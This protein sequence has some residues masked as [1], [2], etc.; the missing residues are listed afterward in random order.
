[1]AIGSRIERRL[2]QAVSDAQGAGA[3]PLL[4]A[5]LRY[6][7]FPGGHRIR[8]RLCLSVAEACGAAD[9]AAADAAAAAIELLHCASLVHDDLPCF[10][11]ADLRRGKASVHCEFGVPIAVLT[12][13]AL[14]VLAFETLTKGSAESP[15]CLA[16]LATIIAGAVGSPRGIVAGQ[17]WE[18]EAA[19]SLSDYQRAKTGALFLAATMAGAAAA[20]V[21]SK[22]WGV[23]GL[24]LG[25]AYQ[26]ADDLRDVLCDAEELGKPIDQDAARFRPNAAA[27]LGVEGAKARLKTLIR[28]AMDSIPACPGAEELRAIIKRADAA[29]PARAAGARGRLRRRRCPPRR[30]SVGTAWRW[31]DVWIGLRN[32]LIADPGFQRWAA[33]FPLTKLIARRRARALFDLCAGFVYSQILL[34]CVRLGVFDLL[35]EGPQTVEALASAMDLSPEAA[36]RLL[37]A[38][39]S[40]RLLRALPGNRFALADLGASLRGNPSIAAFIEHHSLLYD[41]LRDPVALLRGQ[42]GTKLSRFWPYS[43]ARPKAGDPKAA[44][45][46]DIGETPSPLHGAYSELMSASQALVGED[47]LDAYP[48]DRHRALLDVGGGEGAFLAIAAKRSPRLRLALFRPAARRRAGAQGPGNPGTRRPARRSSPAAFSTTRCRKAAMWRR[49]CGSSTITTTNRAMVI[50]RRCFQAL[51]AGGVLLLAEPM[52]GTPGAEPWAT[53]ISA[54]TCWRWAGAVR[55]RPPA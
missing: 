7:V 43:E 41:D 31:G 54:S 21:D 46:A 6:A 17:A 14:I 45:A 24:T 44:E 23:L 12:G 39:T 33:A 11:D 25:E 42:A 27:L 53:L 52:A 2:D 18:C 47:I 5:A 55:G 22:P 38:A 3:P 16:S 1:M 9:P 51:P 28:E 26:V 15:A 30:S 35:A 8:P 32:R 50:L 20:G 37:R 19:V 4:A 48:L 13:D 36:L 34:A 49:W 40:L 10:D 29:V